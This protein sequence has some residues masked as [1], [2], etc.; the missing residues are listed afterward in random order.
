M[1]V[2][3]AQSKNRDGLLRI[4]FIQEEKVRK[5]ITIYWTSK[6]E[7][8]WKEGKSDKDKI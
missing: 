6:V 8:Y 5:I 2:L 3:I 4:L 1:G 7:K